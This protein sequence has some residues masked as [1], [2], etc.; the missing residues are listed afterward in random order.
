[1]LVLQHT[2]SVEPSRCDVWSADSED[3]TSPIFAFAAFV[4][5]SRSSCLVCVALII[6]ACSC[7]RCFT[8]ITEMIF[9][10]N[11]LVT[12][13]LR[14]S[15]DVRRSMRTCQQST[16]SAGDPSHF[17]L[18]LTPG[19][20]WRRF[21]KRFETVVVPQQLDRSNHQTRCRCSPSSYHQANSTC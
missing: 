8:L 11:A 1:M 12:E 13:W 20:D 18:Q 21:L 4:H 10:V 2:P 19:R 3:S 17:V 7:S 14:I 6:K 5:S 16:S 9:R 15:I